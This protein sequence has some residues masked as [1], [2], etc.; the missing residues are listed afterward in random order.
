MR[1][2]FGRNVISV[3]QIP[4]AVGSTAQNRDVVERQAGESRF[5]GDRATSTVNRLTTVSDRRAAFK[6]VVVSFLFSDADN[7]FGEAA[8]L[9]RSAN[10]QQLL[11][12]SNR[13][14]SQEWRKLRIILLLMVAQVLLVIERR[15]FRLLE[16]VD[17]D[18]V[19]MLRRPGD[20]NWRAVRFEIQ[21]ISAFRLG[22][23]RR[24]RI[25]RRV[26]FREIGERLVIELV[27]IVAIGI[28]NQFA[29]FATRLQEWIESV[30]IADDL[31]ESR[32]FDDIRKSVVELGRTQGQQTADY[33]VVVGFL[34]KNANSLKLR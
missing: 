13:L 3:A 7:I 14:L 11:L 5:V 18:H 32:P 2:H 15:S 20:E 29:S 6:I 1:V 28:G 16:F 34:S 17:V 9:R 27:E 12:L 19:A 10:R 33:R 31:F 23:G 24:N 22:Y 4:A 26:V 30:I 21:Q 25:E 8:A